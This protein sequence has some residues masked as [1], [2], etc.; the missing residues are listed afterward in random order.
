MK[1]YKILSVLFIMFLCFILSGCT[2]NEK[3]S[4]QDDKT[5]LVNGGEWESYHKSTIDIIDFH[6]ETYVFFDDGFYKYDSSS[7]YEDG[8][9]TYHRSS[10]EYHISNGRIYFDEEKNEG[11]LDYINWRS[12]SC[13]SLDYSLEIIDSNNIKIGNYDFSS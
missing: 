9:A 11:S 8:A 12:H 3:N 2:A 4:L 10:G 5:T 1:I 7:S 6:L 13:R